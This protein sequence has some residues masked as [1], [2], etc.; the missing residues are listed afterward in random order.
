M[1]DRL[2]LEP[3]ARCGDK[4]L[5]GACWRPGDALKHLGPLPDSGTPVW[6]K[7]FETHCGLKARE[8]NDWHRPAPG[9]GWGDDDYWCPECLTAAGIPFEMRSDEMSAGDLPLP[10]QEEERG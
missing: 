6:S 5:P 1:S 10:R 2:E 9:D 3:A 7:R 8:T 4:Y